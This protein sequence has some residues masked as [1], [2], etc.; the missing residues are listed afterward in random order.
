M[1]LSK[2]AA[3]R[4]IELALPDCRMKNLQTVYRRNTPRNTP[5]DTQRDTQ[6]TMQ[7]IGQ[8]P[9]AFKGI[10]S[11]ILIALLVFG[12]VLIDGC[13]VR[14]STRDS[15]FTADTVAANAGKEKEPY[16]AIVVLGCGLRPDG[17]PAGRL[18]DRL[19]CAV[20][21]YRRGLADVILMSG[22]SEHA[23]Y[24]ETGAMK[25]FAQA[26]GIPAEAI[27]TDPYGLSTYDSMWRAAHV[28]GFSRILVVTQ[29]YHLYR[30]LYIAR[31]F[32]LDADGVPAAFHDTT[33]QPWY[34]FREMLARWKDV[35][36]CMREPT[37]AYQK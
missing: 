4:R 27:M 11:G 14:V 35:I 26:Q 7:R 22:D 30:A 19:L 1:P 21:L 37:A 15:V 25:A 18:E 31:H 8:I 34:E 12:G 36:K 16:D 24:D 29:E 17:T 3:R 23:T 28:F 5:R 13:A 2:N 9:I 33:K 6:R 10:L 32:S 20:D